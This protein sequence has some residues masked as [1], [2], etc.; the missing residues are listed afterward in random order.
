M[1]GKFFRFGKS[2]KASGLSQARL[3]ELTNEIFDGLRLC[4]KDLNSSGYDKG[5]Y[6]LN[7]EASETAMLHQAIVNGTVDDTTLSSITSPLSIASA[8]KQVLGAHAPLLTYNLYSDFVVRDADIKSLMARIPKENFEFLRVFIPHLQRIV[9]DKNAPISLNNLVSCLA[10]EIIRPL[11]TVDDD[12][13]ASDSMLKVQQRIVNQ[14][15]T[16][17]DIIFNSELTEANGNIA[18]PSDLPE[19]S[20]KITFPKQRSAPSEDEL[21]E[22]LPQIR[23]AI[24]IGMKPKHAVI[25]FSTVKEAHD[26]VE[27]G[28][29][30]LDSD[31]KD[32]DRNK[33]A[34]PNFPNDTR[35]SSVASDALEKNGSDDERDNSNNNGNSNKK[36]NNTTSNSRNSIEDRNKT[37]MKTLTT[38]Q[39]IVT[40]DK[41]KHTPRRDFSKVNIH[42]DTEE[43]EDNEVEVDEEEP[44]QDNKRNHNSNSISNN[45]NNSNNSHH[46][47]DDSQQQQQMKKNHSHPSIPTLQLDDVINT[48]INT[49][50]NESGNENMSNRKSPTATSPATRD[51]ISPGANNSDTDSSEDSEYRKRIN[52]KSNTKNNKNNGKSSFQDKSTSKHHHQDI[53]ISQSMI[54]GEPPSELRG[55][56]MSPSLSTST[57]TSANNIST[58]NISIISHTSH[59]VDGGGNSR[60]REYRDDHPMSTSKAQHKSAMST[61]NVSRVQVEEDEEEEEEQNGRRHRHRNVSSDSNHRQDHTTT[62]ATAV[63]NT[64][65][66][67]S[68]KSSDMSR[69]TGRGRSESET[70]YA[71]RHAPLDTADDEQS[72]PLPRRKG[73][74]WTTADDKDKDDLVVR[75][76]NALLAGVGSRENKPDL[77]SIAHKYPAVTVHH[78]PQTSSPAWSESP[79]KQVHHLHQPASPSSSSSRVKS[80]SLELHHTETAAFK[81][82]HQHQHHPSRYFNPQVSSESTVLQGTLGRGV[83]PFQLSAESPPAAAAATAAMHYDSL[84]PESFSFSERTQYQLKSNGR[85][86]PEANENDDFGVQRSQSHAP[87][88][89][90]QTQTQAQQYVHS[91]RSEW[92]LPNNHPLNRRVKQLEGEVNSLRNELTLSSHEMARWE[93]DWTEELTVLRVKNQALQQE[94]KEGREAARKLRSELATKD[95]ELA[96]VTASQEAAER[97][98]DS[99][100]AT[101]EREAL[102]TVLSLRRLVS[103]LEQQRNSAVETTKSLSTEV[104]ELRDLHSKATQEALRW[105]NRALAAEQELYGTA[106]KQG[107]MSANNILQSLHLDEY[108]TS[109]NNNT[110][111]GHASTTTKSPETQSPRKKQQQQQQQHH[112]KKEMREEDVHMEESNNTPPIHGSDNDNNFAKP[113]RSVLPAKTT[114]REETERY[115]SL[116][117]HKVSTGLLIDQYGLDLVDSSEKIQTQRPPMSQKELHFHK[118]NQREEEAFLNTGWEAAE[119]Y[120]LP[121]DLGLDSATSNAASSSRYKD[122]IPHR[123][124]S[125]VTHTEHRQTVNQ[126]TRNQ[127]AS[128]SIHPKSSHHYLHDDLTRTGRQLESLSVPYADPEPEPEYQHEPFYS[129]LHEMHPYSYRDEIASEKAPIPISVPMSSS[130]LHPQKHFLNNNSHKNHNNDINGVNPLHSRQHLPP[131]QP[132]FM[133]Y[134][135]HLKEP[136]VAQFSSHHSFN[137]IANDNTLSHKPVTMGAKPSFPT[138]FQPKSEKLQNWYYKS[139]PG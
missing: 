20:V 9:D 52:H 97:S 48:N 38:S 46:M 74:S 131:S 136:A 82:Q 117:R 64:S 80:M 4:I 122:T 107:E 113:W 83:N 67:N 28:L 39:V 34:S 125:M 87:Q 119:P 32:R 108:A 89:P 121:E 60:Q 18:D 138:R 24:M 71:T 12:F 26:C 5:I 94:T 126:P 105:R 6:N 41:Q 37:S 92:G 103:L 10:A 55:L 79:V 86:I 78:H 135:D 116:R 51:G 102:S 68:S 85:D 76:S 93:A 21:K 123:S 91:E 30:E 75:L 65:S 127:S 56:H 128:T 44:V 109:T 14:I 96:A 16:K 98:V 47:N 106:V 2:S 19:R 95:A 124:S 7:G 8:I 70:P 101:A 57:S 63:T 15:L 73:T 45:N 110:Q 33:T 53:S 88:I 58:N 84:Q 35:R 104:L 66:R 59:G 133:S 27:T 129:H 61:S 111:Q 112:H 120:M 100:K 43:D 29:D 81:Q 62:T 130:L 13:D 54:E 50:V 132:Q 11:N 40:N 72:P 137:T 1:F 36:E 42:S 31:Y 134:Y 49:N 118:Q 17:Y 25:V 22:L 23:T 69:L 114:A 77:A 90:I 115:L 139:H 3:P 99:A